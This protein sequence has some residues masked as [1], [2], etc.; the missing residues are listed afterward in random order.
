MATVS[1]RFSQAMALAQQGHVEE[2]MTMLSRLAMEGDPDAMFALGDACWRGAGVPQD[3]P[4]GREIFRYASDAGHPIARR[5]YTNLLASGIA[6]PR[7]WRLALERLREEAQSDGRRAH[8]LR[9]IAA[10]DLTPE[11]DPKTVPEG[12]RICA[13]PDVMQFPNAFTEEECDY[14]ILIAE[15]TYEPSLVADGSGRDVRD[16]IRTSDGSTIHWLIEDPA[17]QALNR[18]IAAI[19]NT[20][21]DQGEPL[22]ILRYHPGQQY[23]RHTDWLGE[24]NRRIKTTLVYLNEGYGG[25]ETVFPKAELTVKG[26]KGDAIVFRNCGEDGYLDPMSEHAGMP[27]TSGIK[28]LASRWIRDRRHTA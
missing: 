11:G 5:A 17:T 2:A 22:L 23:R 12:R 28:Y 16:P 4:Q 1:P 27:V 8:M 14:L 10:M 9:L 15:P 7:D 25:G 18:R 13:S 24:A 19:S 20:Q 6:G 21:V 26:R 3:M